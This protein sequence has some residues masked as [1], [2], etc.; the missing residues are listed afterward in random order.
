MW[1]V[2][3]RGAGGL[4]VDIGK[5]A[6]T[7]AT[8]GRAFGFLIHQVTQFIRITYIA[9][10]SRGQEVD[11]LRQVI[12]LAHQRHLLLLLRLFGES[13]LVASCVQEGF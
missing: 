6:T 8:R 12:N 7:E 10:S 9:A 13:T 3:L 4:I 1:R 11:I 5:G 2:A